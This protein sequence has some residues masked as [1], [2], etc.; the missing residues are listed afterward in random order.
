M[1]K[2]GIEPKILHLLFVCIAEPAT[3]DS[4]ECNKCDSPS[5]CFMAQLSAKETFYFV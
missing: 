5:F 3:A 1:L 2:E 4:G